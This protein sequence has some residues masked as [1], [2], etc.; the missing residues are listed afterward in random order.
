MH[1]LSSPLLL[2]QIDW[3]RDRDY[4]MLTHKYFL[5]TNKFTRAHLLRELYAHATVCP[6]VT[7]AVHWLLG[8]LF[9]KND[10]AHHLGE[11]PL[12]DGKVMIYRQLA[13]K[14]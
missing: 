13:D 11:T 4:P 2:T 12:P 1:L 6:A 7:E 3:V 14:H 8:L 9:F 5:S 10:K